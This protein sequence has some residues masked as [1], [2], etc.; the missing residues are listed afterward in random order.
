MTEV[1]GHLRR[2]KT[3]AGCLRRMREGYRLEC[4]N[5]SVECG[6][7]EFVVKWV[8]SVKDSGYFPSL[9]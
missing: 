9:E 5:P 8:F 7:Q 3:E 6:R 1:N 4:L 2:G